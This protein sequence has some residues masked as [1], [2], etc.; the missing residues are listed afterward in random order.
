MYTRNLTFQLY[1]K[2]CI[3]TVE[4]CYPADTL[5]ISLCPTKWSMLTDLD[6]NCSRKIIYDAFG[7]SVC[8]DQLQIR[9]P[10]VWICTW[11]ETKKILIICKRLITW[12]GCRD[13][14][15]TN[16]LRLKIPEKCAIMISW[17][18]RIT[19]WIRHAKNYNKAILYE[20]TS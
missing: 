5:F 11:R 1:N 13:K 12:H 6:E 17:H 2:G 3:F 4:S 14:H 10:F 19:H 8:P 9:A 20:Y 15:V 7:N 16:E 18:I